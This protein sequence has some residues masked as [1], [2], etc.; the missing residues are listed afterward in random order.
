MY[1]G[2]IIV[3]THKV[4]LDKCLLSWCFKKL[5]IPLPWLMTPSFFET[6]PKMIRCVDGKHLAEGGGWILDVAE[7]AFSGSNSVTACLSVQL[8]MLCKDG[9]SPSDRRC[10]YTVVALF[11]CCSTADFPAIFAA[12]QRITRAHSYTYW[13]F[14]CT[15]STVSSLKIG[16]RACWVFVHWELEV[17]V[18]TLGSSHE[19]P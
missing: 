9:G 10:K 5:L 14:Q 2:I 18:D 7:M 17:H 11:T 1:V 19:L 16:L 12:L 6:C 8:C 15:Q 4:L 3:S 13:S